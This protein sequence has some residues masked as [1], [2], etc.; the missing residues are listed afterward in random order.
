MSERSQPPPCQPTPDSADTYEP[1]KREWA[2]EKERS[3]AQIEPS[4]IDNTSSAVNSEFSPNKRQGDIPDSLVGERSTYPCLI[5]NFQCQCLIDSGSQVTLISESL[6]KKL[7]KDVHPLYDLVLFHGGGGS[8]PYIGYTNVQLQ[9]EPSFA[10][11]SKPCT[12]M[13]LIIPDNRNTDIHPV[14]V[15]TNSGVFRNLYINCKEGPEMEVDAVCSSIYKGIQEKM[16]TTSPP[17]DVNTFPFE[18][19]PVAKDI[20]DSLLCEIEQRREVFA[21]H[22]WD[23]GVTSLAQHEIRLTDETPFRQRSR[24]V[25]PSDLKDLRDHIEELLRNGII[26]ESHSPFASP[27]V[28]VRKKTGALRMCVDYRQLNQRTKADQ[29]VVPRIQEAL[30][31]LNGCSW[32]SVLDL[33]SGFYQIPMKEADKE[34]TAFICPAGFYQFERMPFVINFP[35]PNFN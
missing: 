10:G 23:V 12:T 30:D 7:G 16:P 19:G 26:K 24:R 11:T 22:E 25:S 6:C 4:S 3:G 18:W 35:F 17:P 2:P 1:G 28:L 15:G 5:D 31:C 32:F 34:K 9:F 13:A 14:V 29:Y 8:I 27:I 33:K 21:T 20:K